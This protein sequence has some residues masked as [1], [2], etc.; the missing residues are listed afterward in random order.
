[1]IHIYLAPRSRTAKLMKAV[2]PSTQAR[3]VKTH[4][5]AWNEKPKT[6]DIV[7]TPSATN[8][9]TERFAARMGTSLVAVLPEAYDWLQGR[10]KAAIDSNTDLSI[11]DAVLNTVD[12][13]AVPR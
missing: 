6:A 11:V 3:H 5:I 10:V 4:V 13:L 7:V 2:V 1:M 8:T 12:P 9:A